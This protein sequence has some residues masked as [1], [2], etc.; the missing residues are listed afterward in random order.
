L[1]GSSIAI[2]ADATLWVKRFEF[3]KTAEATDIWT[4]VLLA[5]TLP[6]TSRHLLKAVF[7]CNIT[8][9]EAVEA[10][11]RAEKDESFMIDLE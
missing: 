7:G 3:K 5:W 1:S 11:T 2:E 9:A 6:R 8:C 10:A 4:G